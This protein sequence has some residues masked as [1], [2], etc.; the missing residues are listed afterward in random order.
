MSK[1]MGAAIA[2]ALGLSV[3]LYGCGNAAKTEE[4]AATEAVESVEEEA[5]DE[6][7]K[8]AAEAEA[9]AKAEAE[10]AAQAEAEA[11]AALEAEHE[12]TRAAA[13]GEGLSVFVG[14]VHIMTGEELCAYEDKPVEM[15]YEDAASDTTYVILELDE[16]THVVGERADGSPGEGDADHI[17]IGRNI[18]AFDFV[19]DSASF[20]TDYDGQRVCVAGNPWFQTDVSLPYAPR[21]YDAQLL[22]VE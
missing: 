7:A 15:F 9:A 1:V 19:E 3:A 17:G 6:A 5:E 4:P 11:A 16:T 8:A 12:S 10:A 21:M 20:W 14:T 2:V 13:E 18:P 22:Y